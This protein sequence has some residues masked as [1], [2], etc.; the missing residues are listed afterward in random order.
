MMSKDFMTQC[1]A[2]R[3]HTVCYIENQ[4]EESSF[5][6]VG[7]DAKRTFFENVEMTSRRR[8]WTTQA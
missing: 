6:S 7:G 8:L 2:F 4:F 5:K 3:F 1:S